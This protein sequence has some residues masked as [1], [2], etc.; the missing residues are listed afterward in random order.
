[1]DAD[2][3]NDEELTTT[4][5]VAEEEEE[6]PRD[7]RKGQRDPKAWGRQTDGQDSGDAATEVTRT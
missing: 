3:Y 4:T 5:T 1:M 7:P 2:C 6:K